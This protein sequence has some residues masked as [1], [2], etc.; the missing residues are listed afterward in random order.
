MVR[1]VVIFTGGS[2]FVPTLALA[3]PITDTYVLPVPFW[4]Y[5]YGCAAV[6]VVSF[7]VLGYFWSAD[8]DDSHG[9]TWEVS[10]NVLL[11]AVGRVILFVLRIGAVAALAIAIAAGFLGTNDPT[12]NANL[13]LFWVVFLLGFTYATLLFGDLYSLINPWQVIACLARGRNR[14]AVSPPLRYPEAAGY[15]PAFISYLA[16]VWME[17]FLQPSPLSLSV[18][19]VAYTAIA[20]MGSYAFGEEDW[21]RQCDVFSVFFRLVATLAPIE[22]TRSSDGKSRR[23]RVRPPFVG[24]LESPPKAGIS[25]VLFVLLMLAS[26]TYDAFHQT[27]VWAGWFWRP[28]LRISEPLWGDDLGKAQ[29]LLENW[30]LVYQRLGLLAAPFLY[31]GV[32]FL[33]LAWARAVTGVNATLRQLALDFSFSL[34]PIA[35]AYN[36]THYL[37]TLVGSSSNIMQRLSDPLGWGWNLLN[38]VPTSPYQQSSMS[39]AVVWHTQ[40][41]LIVIGHVASVYLAHIIALRTFHTGRKVIVSQLSLLCLMVVLT[42]IGLWVLALPLAG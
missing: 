41:A 15:W 33:C 32:Y 10:S 21:F 29:H 1:R 34:I 17:L 14:I 6:L 39:M 35:V 22:Y 38:V 7:A 42:G 5:L 9:R 18:L 31:L 23:V 25:L 11:D 2:C 37:P 24:A 4:M 40:V 26:T 13:S 20:W 12:R 3:H 27:V 30:F 8:G 36:M 28:M 16:L 19:L